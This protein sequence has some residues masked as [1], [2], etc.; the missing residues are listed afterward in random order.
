M[1]SGSGVG[2][3]CALHRC[4]LATGAV[5]DPQSL[6]LHQTLLFHLLYFFLRRI[7]NI[8]PTFFIIGFIKTVKCA[9]GTSAQKEKL[10]A[11]RLVASREN[12]ST[13]PRYSFFSLLREAP[14]F[15]TVRST[16]TD[17]YP[18]C[19][20]TEKNKLKYAGLFL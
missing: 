7:Q 18:Q 4:S 13:V 8:Q 10:I 12:D 14:P 9:S 19:L 1:H 20:G 3:P 16:S 5:Q 2:Q 11:E 15:S 17:R 6:R